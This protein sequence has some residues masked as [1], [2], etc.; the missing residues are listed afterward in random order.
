MTGFAIVIIIVAL[1]VIVGNIMLLKHSAKVKMGIRNF[2]QDPIEKA[3][4]TLE[5]REDK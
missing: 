1:G 3:K 2:N 5:E 4:R